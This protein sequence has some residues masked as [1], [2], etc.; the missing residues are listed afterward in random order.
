[1]HRVQRQ[2]RR[3]LCVFPLM[4]TEL[5]HLTPCLCKRFRAEHAIF[6]YALCGA[7]MPHEAKAAIAHVAPDGAIPVARRK[8]RGDTP[9]RD[10]PSPVG[11]F[12]DAHRQHRRR[13]SALRFL[14]C[15]ARWRR[16]L[17]KTAVAWQ[18]Y[19]FGRWRCGCLAILTPRSQTQ[20]K[21]SG[22]RATSA[23]P[24]ICCLRCSIHR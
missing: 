11:P 21:R 17:A 15:I 2:T 23:K 20:S 14:P 4:A 9:A 22:R 5:A 16:D 8:A 24:S 18:P 19:A 10:R 6:D 7:P 3:G 13:P 1:V 12:T